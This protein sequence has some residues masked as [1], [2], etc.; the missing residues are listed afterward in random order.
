MTIGA[1]C[2]TLRNAHANDD[3]RR[4]Y[5]CS[6]AHADGDDAGGGCRGRSALLLSVADAR[7]VYAK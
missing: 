6:R 5:F 4:R 3:S 7:S 1:R 2:A